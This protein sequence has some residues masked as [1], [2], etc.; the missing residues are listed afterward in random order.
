MKEWTIGELA[1]YECWKCQFKWSQYPDILERCPKC[2]HEYVWWLNH[3][4][5]IER[6]KRGDYK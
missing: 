1:I 4:L 5:T 2:G 6:F 3:P